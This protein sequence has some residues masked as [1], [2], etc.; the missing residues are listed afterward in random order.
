[1]LIHAF[2]V[3]LYMDTRVQLDQDSHPQ[4]KHLSEYFGLLLEFARMGENESLFLLQ[5]D[6]VSTII[7]FFMGHKAQESY[8]RTNSSAI[9]L[10][11]ERRT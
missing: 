6:A 5:I 7:H 3:L 9:V 4:C 11:V 1:M 10:I 2:C 8:V